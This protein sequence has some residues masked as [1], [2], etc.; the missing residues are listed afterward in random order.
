[1]AKD[2]RIGRDIASWHRLEI[3]GDEIARSL[4]ERCWSSYIK[5]I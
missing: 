4:K 1:M 3:T 5:P 2:A